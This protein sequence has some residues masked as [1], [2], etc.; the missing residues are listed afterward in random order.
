MSASIYLS[1]YLSSKLSS[2]DHNL[3]I[4]TCRVHWC[5]YESGS[6]LLPRPALGWRE[7]TWSEV[8]L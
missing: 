1:I 6:K 7:P 5:K 2:K 3:P 8:M 4:E